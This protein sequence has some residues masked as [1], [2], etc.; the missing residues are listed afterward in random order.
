MGRRRL[1][2]Y[3]IALD[4][5]R[6][7]LS[8]AD[9]ST[10]EEYLGAVQDEV[11]KIREQ[12]YQDSPRLA[13]DPD[14]RMTFARGSRDIEA[15]FVRAVRNQHGEALKAEFMDAFGREMREAFD[16]ILDSDSID[17]DDTEAMVAFRQ[18]VIENLQGSFKGAHNGGQNWISEGQLTKSASTQ[19]FAILKDQE[20]KKDPE[21]AER[22][23]EFYRSLNLDELEIRGLNSKDRE[24][25][26]RD[27]DAILVKMRQQEDDQDYA[28]DLRKATEFAEGVT[29]RHVLSLATGK[30]EMSDDEI[31][32]MENELYTQL[33][34][35]GSSEAVAAQAS[36]SAVS[37]MLNR[38]AQVKSSIRTGE[39]NQERVTYWRNIANGPTSNID[40][41]V[42]QLIDDVQ[43]D[44]TLSALEKETVIGEFQRRLDDNSVSLQFIQ[45]EYSDNFTSD[46]DSFI[47]PLKTALSGLDPDEDYVLISQL[48]GSITKIRDET[49]DAAVNFMNQWWRDNG[50]DESPKQQ[51]EYLV[52]KMTNWKAQYNASIKEQAN[53]GRGPYGFLGTAQAK[54]GVFGAAKTDAELTPII[55]FRMPEGDV[56]Q[57]D[58]VFRNPEFGFL[59]EFTRT[60][61]SMKKGAILSPDQVGE[62]IKSGA[63]GIQNM[64]S[65]TTTGP[66]KLS[67]GYLITKQG[68]TP[69]ARD[70][71]SI[72][73]SVEIGR[74][75]FVVFVNG[76][77]NTQQSKA[78]TEAVLVSRQLMG[79]TSTEVLGDKIIALGGAFS[80]D[81]AQQKRLF[82]PAVSLLLTEEEAAQG[83]K[84]NA[85][86][87]TL[88]SEVPAY[89]VWQKL[90]I[91]HPEKT[92]DEFSEFIRTQDLIR[93]RRKLRLP[94]K[95]AE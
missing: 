21:A 28:K 92:P 77:E 29:S 4:E 48:N 85:T 69:R 44:P 56:A 94:N 10:Q 68:E 36:A 86:P 63:G 35:R 32:A 43:N 16:S 30:R 2:E 37:S 25:V 1:G 7:E 60:L 79:F 40:R 76:E 55:G 34:Q 54:T 6:H 67:E 41:H 5:K 3:E 80:L 75:G 66:V 83:F 64:F 84:A 58:R 88:M 20:E 11:A 38:A 8:R 89:K 42:T 93:A 74:T 46:V 14:F 22:L 27:A 13:A 47:G 70:R 61:D 59:K 15:N 26:L 71:E 52:D 51:R 78:V 81:S 49:K 45:G 19:F 31:L 72:E 33:I 90:L 62:V 24:D 82:D 53:L 73:S 95:K 23:I 18:Q 39:S 57:P 50:Y 65:T 91:L 12:F 87:G 9:F 17:P